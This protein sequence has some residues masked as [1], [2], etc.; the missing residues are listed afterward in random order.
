M[1]KFRLQINLKF[2]LRIRL[3]F[4]LRIRLL[5]DIVLCIK[6]SFESDNQAKSI[7]SLSQLSG[8]LVGE[9]SI[10]EK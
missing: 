3:K 6:L 9:I 7:K 10:R 1:G 8:P 2:R 5:D 4:T